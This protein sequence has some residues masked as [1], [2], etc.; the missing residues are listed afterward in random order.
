MYRERVLPTVT[1]F[2]A[3]LLLIPA[4]I[5]ALAPINLA[6]G[7]VMSIGIYGA[8]VWFF[9]AMSPRIEVSATYFRAGKGRI[10]R[11]FLGSAVAVPAEDAFAELHGNLDARAWLCLRNWVPG[12]V[13]V[14]LTDPNDPTP[15]WLVS[16]RHP[17]EL[18]VALNA[19]ATSSTAR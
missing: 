11:A 3:A 12:L 18:A 13:K 9:V 4:V 1:W 14:P 10:E 6:L 19:H 15:Y 8:A 2:L 5:L 7:I 17:E 16:T